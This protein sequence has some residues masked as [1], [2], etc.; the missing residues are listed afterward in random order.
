MRLPNKVGYALLEEVAS[1]GEGSLQDVTA[2]FNGAVS[3]KIVSL[4]HIYFLDI[5]NGVIVSCEI[6]VVLVLLSERHFPSREG[7]LWYGS[8]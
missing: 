3:F 7:L 5:E 1:I 8:I 4:H 2:S 6:M